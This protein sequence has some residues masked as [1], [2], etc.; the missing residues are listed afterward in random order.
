MTRAAF[1]ATGSKEYDNERAA[2]TAHLT[3]MEDNE[4]TTQKNKLTAPIKPTLFL[5]S[6]LR[7]NDLNVQGLSI[8]GSDMTA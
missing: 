6:K 1:A 2:S 4:C 8:V 7:V 5:F 3:I